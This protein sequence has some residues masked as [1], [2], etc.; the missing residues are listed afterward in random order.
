MSDVGNAA[1]VYEDLKADI[2]RMGERLAQLEERDHAGETALRPHPA[3]PFVGPELDGE[4]HN[5]DGCPT[6]VPA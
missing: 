2:A 5:R 3:T 1:A 4:R 6:G